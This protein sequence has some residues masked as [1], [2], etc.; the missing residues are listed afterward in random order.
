[1]QSGLILIVSHGEPLGDRAG[2]TFLGTQSPRW[3]DR[4]E[5]LAFSKRGLLRPASDANRHSAL[6]SGH[7]LP[8]A[9]LKPCS[10]RNLARW[11]A[12]RRHVR[13]QF[14]FVIWVPVSQSFMHFSKYSV[15]SLRDLLEESFWPNTAVPAKISESEPSRSK[16]R[17]GAPKVIATLATLQDK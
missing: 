10:R 4:V 6:R 5:G 8:T 14:F 13:S 7:G 15:N 11:F 1:M 17:T 9:Y 2:G 16:T 12:K 3:V